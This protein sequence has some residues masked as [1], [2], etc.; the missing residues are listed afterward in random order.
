MRRTKM[1]G[2]LACALVA[3]ALPSWSH[4]QAPR[5]DAIWARS[6]AGQ[7]ITLDGV[8]DEFAWTKAETKIVKYGVDNGIPGSGYKI[9]AGRI[10]RDSTFATLKF[11]VNGNKLYLGAV[12]RDSS[13]GGSA[14]F[15]RFDGLLMAL[16]DHRDPFATISGPVEYLY[17]WWHPEDPTPDAVGKMPGFRGYWSSQSDT[18]P[19]TP[20]QIAAWNAVT[21]VRGGQTNTDTT[22]DS[23]WVVEMVFDVGVM[24]YTPSAVGGDIM[25]WNISVY[26]CDW[27]WPLS[28]PRFTSYRTWWQGPWGNQMHYNEVR[29]HARPDVTI[30]SGPVPFIGP[31]VRIPNAGTQAVPNIDGFLTDPVWSKVPGFDMTYGDFPLRETYPGVMRWRAGFYQPTVN[32]GTAFVAN[33][34]DATIKWFYKGDSLYIGF[35]VRDEVVQSPAAFDRWDGFIV[36]IQDTA[37]RR[38]S[39]QN[40]ESRRLGF[41]V[42]PAPSGTPIATDYLPFMRDTLFAAKL[43]LKLKPGTSVDTVG[44]TADQGYTAELMVNMRKLGFPA[45]LGTR[46]LYIGIDMQDGDSYVPF[47]DSYGTRTWWGREY[48]H[49]CCPANAYFDPTMVLAVG[50]EVDLTR[51]GLLGN[52][53]NPFRTSTLVKFV[54]AAPARVSLEVYDLQGRA[55]AKRGLGIQPPGERQAAFT[56]SGLR[57]GVYLYRVKLADPVSGAERGAMAGKMMILN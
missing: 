23:S 17:S 14:T 51:P 1:A 41:H 35:D 21:K 43:G 49:E 50:D 47:T 10:P 54:L 27:F 53:P 12:M 6:T 48:E 30:N 56:R 45:G 29:I 33:P 28:G 19:R 44:A 42:G 46:P 24:G 52:F 5:T 40:L 38:E 57:T 7:T 16:K 25:E 36:T 18:I 3:L 32:G 2:W 20:E 34:G 22:P 4:A 55:V 9:E 39:D 13:I 37:V 11:L 26:D 8:L 15:N 31:E